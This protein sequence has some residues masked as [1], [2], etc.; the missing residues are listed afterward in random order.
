[1][2]ASRIDPFDGEADAMTVFGGD[3]MLRW[4]WFTVMAEVLVAST[5]SL[6]RGMEAYGGYALG[7]VQI[8]PDFLEVVGRYERFWA[9]IPM[10][11]DGTLRP[12]WRFT[13][14]L[15]LYYLEER[16]RLQYAFMYGDAGDGLFKGPRAE[17]VVLFT[18][19][20]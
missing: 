1:M 12:A 15:N 7:A 5:D 17:H 3:F 9:D 18:I 6:R 8:I 19:Q 2:E 10:I 20:M 16:F 13:G 11:R 14:G 4:R